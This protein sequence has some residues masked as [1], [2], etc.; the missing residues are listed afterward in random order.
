MLTMKTPIHLFLQVH[1]RLL[2]IQQK[3]NVLRQQQQYQDVY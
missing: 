2:R 3:S 1:E